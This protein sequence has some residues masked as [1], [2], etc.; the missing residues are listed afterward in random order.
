MSRAVSDDDLAEQARAWY[1]Q[2]PD[3]SVSQ[4]ACQFPGQYREAAEA[5]RQIKESTP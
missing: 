4:F 5:L 1:A 2:H 3:A